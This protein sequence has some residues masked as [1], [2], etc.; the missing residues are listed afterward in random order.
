MTSGEKVLHRL[1]LWADG[2]SNSKKPVVSENYDELL[3]YEPRES[4]H[5]ILNQKNVTSKY[6][7]SVQDMIDQYGMEMVD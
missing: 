6:R 3:F 1:R 4:F 2:M 5:K 7:V